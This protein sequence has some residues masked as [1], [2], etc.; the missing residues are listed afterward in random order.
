MKTLLPKPYKLRC[1]RCGAT[2]IVS[3]KNFSI[4]TFILRHCDDCGA[5]MEKCDFNFFDKMLGKDQRGQPDD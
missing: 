4:S 2:K 3:I 1:P 5:M